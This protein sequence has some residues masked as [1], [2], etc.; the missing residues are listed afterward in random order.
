MRSFRLRAILVSLL[1]HARSYN[2][3]DDTDARALV[4]LQIEY[5]LLLLGNWQ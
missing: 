5:A 1:E 2:L 3:I 4:R